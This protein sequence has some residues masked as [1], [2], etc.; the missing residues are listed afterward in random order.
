MS[1]S[2]GGGA[3]A[4]PSPV[5]VVFTGSEKSDIL[6]PDVY[7][8]FASEEEA[9]EFV[10]GSDLVSMIYPD[11]HPYWPG[12]ITL[13]SGMGGYTGFALVCARTATPPNRAYWITSE[14]PYEPA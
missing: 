3:S 8:P 14:E 7:G 6:D 5:F 12:A 1:S 9:L 10:K 4:P 2:R 13:D 11:D